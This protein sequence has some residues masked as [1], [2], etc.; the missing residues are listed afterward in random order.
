MCPI[1]QLP[2]TAQRMMTQHKQTLT[3]LPHC[4]FFFL[5]YSFNF[6]LLS[7][8]A[9]PLLLVSIVHSVF[10]WFLKK[11]WRGES[12]YK[13]FFLSFTSQLLQNSRTVVFAAP[14]PAAWFYFSVVLL[15]SKTSCGSEN[16]E[17]P[18]LKG[19]CPEQ[20]IEELRKSSLPQNND[21]MGQNHPKQLL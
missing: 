8:T 20:L 17:F 4:S 1:G 16:Q 19:E 7:Q 13:L 12:T 3:F 18:P 9:T 21:K 14:I 11:D 15:S 2:A 6:N 10:C 5:P